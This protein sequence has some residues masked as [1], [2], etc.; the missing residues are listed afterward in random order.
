MESF[1][2]RVAASQAWE[3]IVSSIKL[4]VII[5]NIEGSIVYANA[6]AEAMVGNEALVGMDL[7][8]LFTNLAP[9]SKKELQNFVEKACVAAPEGTPGETHIAVE[10]PDR[11]LIQIRSSCVKLGEETEA[12]PSFI[13]E[14]SIPS[15]NYIAPRKT[16]LGKGKEDQSQSIFWES[17]EKLWDSSRTSIEILR[18]IPSAI[19]ICK[20]K[21]SGKLSIIDCNPAAER[22]AGK[23]L[24]QLQGTM[25]DAIWEHA[26]DKSFMKQIMDGYRTSKPFSFED[27]QENDGV[28]QVAYKVQ[29]FFMPNDRAGVIFDDISPQKKA[30]RLLEEENVRLKELDVMKNNFIA[31]TSH[32]LKTPLVSTCGATEF[33][34]ANYG[35]LQHGEEELKFIEMINRGATRLKQLVLSL[36]D[37]SRLQSGKIELEM[38]K[39]DLILIIKRVVDDQ[40]YLLE[41][42][43]QTLTLETPDTLVFMF[44]SPRVEQ[45]LTNLLSNAIKNTQPEGHI[46]IRVTND[47]TEVCISVIDDGVGITK[48]EMDK[49]F[50]QFGKINREGVDMDLNIQGTGLGLFIT[51]EL[52]T[53]HGGRIWAESEGRFKGATFTVA[54][55][56]VLAPTASNEEEPAS[57]A[58]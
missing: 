39:E 3:K 21:K 34:L 41:T 29:T 19:Y 25:L 9:S 35:K 36:L 11:G 16:K 4:G 44:D 24:A 30:E 27:I 18:S 1:K 46:K 53:L 23:L 51:R 12:F 58:E 17:L 33:L 56:M 6:A 15:E 49:L 5:T 57:P 40:A 8:S 22:L 26:A 32:E 20:I 55:P 48:E 45:I 47:D 14:S 50:M 31:I 13:I 52:V 43:N 42:R 7:A 2:D 38:A 10:T 54:L 37:M 28:L